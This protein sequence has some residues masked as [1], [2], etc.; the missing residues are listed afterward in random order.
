MQS[1][2]IEQSPREIS[3]VMLNP[4]A[5]FIESD[6]VAP[7]ASSGLEA[8]LFKSQFVDCMEMQADAATVAQYLDQHQGWFCRCAHPMTVNPLGDNGYALTIGK[9]GSFGYEVEPKIGLNLLPQDQGVYRIH[10]L[11][12]PDYVPPGYDVDFNAAMQLVE[13]PDQSINGGKGVLTRVEWQLDLVVAIQ[14]PKFI[15]KLPQALIQNTGDRVLSQIVRQVSRRLTYKVQEDFHSK[16]GLPMP[17]K[18]KK[19]LF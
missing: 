10:T 19:K 3:E 13:I 2:F 16:L 17:Q 8:V 6:Y 4:G 5:N 11:P 18:S 9:F 12:V 15:H 14:F 7:E 1:Q